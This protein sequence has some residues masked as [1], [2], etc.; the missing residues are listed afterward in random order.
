LKSF[1]EED[2][3]NCLEFSERNSTTNRHANFS[4]HHPFLP[5]FTSNY[6]ART[7]YQAA[8]LPIGAAV[9]IE[10]IAIT[11]D[12]KVELVNADTKL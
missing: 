10:V 4:I 2:N 1:E 7:C 11:G 12:V 9:E 3:N 6:P 5:V 8:A